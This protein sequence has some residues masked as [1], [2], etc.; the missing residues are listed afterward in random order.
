MIRKVKGDLFTAPSSTSLVHCVS[1]CFTMGRGIAVA[2]RNRFGRVPELR[3]QGKGVGDVAVLTDGQRYI[4]YLV[5]KQ[6]YYHKP[7]LRNLER[8]LKALKC[9][10]DAVGVT[11]LAMPLIGCGLDRLQWADVEALLARILTGMD[12]TVYCL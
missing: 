7:T 12:V 11:K 4:Y 8:S 10:C 6:R 5:T 9:H 2:F 3:S 1:A